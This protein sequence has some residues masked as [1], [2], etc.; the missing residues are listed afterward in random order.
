MILLITFISILAR[1]D[2]R[3]KPGE[4]KLYLLIVANIIII[5]R[6]LKS[7]SIISFYIMFEIGA[8]PIFFIIIG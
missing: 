5:F 3:G 2:D 6:L 4:G 1:F 8:L 7:F